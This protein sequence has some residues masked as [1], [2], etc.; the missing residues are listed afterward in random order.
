MSG[1]FA[2]WLLQPVPGV[3]AA[4]APG[5]TTTPI[6]ASFLGN[7]LVAPF[8]R[9]ANNDF[10]AAQDLENIKSCVSQILATKC[11]SQTSQ[12]ELPW[13]SEFGS[14]LH[15]LRHRNQTVVMKELAKHFVRDALA[16]W[17]PRVQV[18]GVAILAD[19]EQPRVLFMRVV[20]HVID[21][22]VPTNRVIFPN[23]VLDLPLAA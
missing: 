14:L 7:G 13:R 17:E 2:T 23:Q 3:I 20:F 6:Q 21:A 9:D 8:Q 19:P 10:K 12:G 11:S 1:N 22:N 5:N 4:G 16:R 18:V 15:T